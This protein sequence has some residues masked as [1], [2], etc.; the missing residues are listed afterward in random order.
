MPLE[1][2]TEPTGYNFGIYQERST[3]NITLPADIITYPGTVFRVISGQLPRG[4]R[5]VGNKIAG[6]PFEVSRTTTYNFVIRATR[7]KSFSDRTF[8]ITIEGEDEP[9]WLTLPGRLPIGA[10]NAYY[11]IDSSFIDFQLDAVDSDTAAGQQLSYF[12]ASGDGELPPGLILLPTGR[13]TG[14]IQPLLSL[15][16]DKKDAG[17][18]DSTLLDE[19]AYDFGIRSTNGYDSYVYDLVTYDFSVGTLRPRKLN[20]NY[21]FEVTITD[22]DSTSKRRFRIFVVG[23]D[24]FRADNVIMQAGTG[25]YTADITYLRYPV[26][27]TAPYLGTRRGANYQ[28]FKI[29]IYEG[30]GELGPVIY[31]LASVNALIE[32]ICQ[33]EQANDNRAGSN[34]IR[35]IKASAKPKVGNKVN[36]N[37]EFIGATTKTYTITEVDTLGADFYR[38]VLNQPLDVSIP[39]GTAIFLGTDSEI[40]PGM[41][42][43]IA[44]GEIFGVIPFRNAVSERYTFTVKAIR[45]GQGTETNIS[46][47][48]FTVDIIGEIEGA[49]KWI[50]GDDL[51]IINVGYPSTA[52]VKAETTLSNPIVLYKLE[53]G[54]LPPGLSL[55]LDGEIVGKVNQIRNQNRYR[56][57]WNPVISYK[58]KDLVK[59]DTTSEIISV[60]RRQNIASVVVKEDHKFKTNEIIKTI[61]SALDFNYSQGVEISVDKFKLLDVLSIEGNGPYQVK[62]EFSS[63]TL[64]PLAPSYISIRGVA[65]TRD[66]FDLTEVSVK[67]T[68]GQGENARFLISKLQ[69]SALVDPVY[70]S[71]LVNII[72]IDPGQHYLSGDTITISGADLPGGGVDGVN[73]LTFTLATGL[74][75]WYRINGNSNAAYNGRFFAVSSTVNSITLSFDSS[76]LEFGTGLISVATSVNTFE[77]QTQLLALS[78]VNYPNAGKSINMV[79]ATGTMA[80]NPVFYVA[81]VDHISDTEFTDANWKLYNFNSIDSTLTSLDNNTTQFD[82]GETSIDREYNFI[83]RASDQIGFAAISKSFKIAVNIPN[84]TNYSNIYARPFLKQSTRTLFKSFINDPF[85]FD[86]VYIYRASDLNFGIQKELRSLIFAGL[87]TVEVEKYISAMGTNNKSKRFKLGNI[88]KAVA[89]EPGTNTV[90]YEVVYLELID[91]LEKGKQTLPFKISTIPKA[92]NITADNN[93]DFY[94]GNPSTDSPFWNRPI[95]LNAS[96]DRT[97][98]FAGDPRTGVKFVSSISIWRARLRAIQ[99]IARERNYLPLWMRSIQEG[100]VTELDYIT[101]IPLCYCRPGGA[102]EILLNI[103]NSNFDFKLIDYT[104][105]RYIIDSVDGYY[106]D[107]YLVFK[108]DR[109]QIV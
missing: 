102:D 101:A 54:I 59:L 50:S 94:N 104:V 109:T 55:N 106:E 24:F 16:Q 97:D 17:T 7:G 80:G 18:Y 84:D 51:G 108:N 48:V 89:K 19:I 78:Y 91:P 33:N 44:S 9:N 74:N 32:G 81:A 25:T 61:S 8:L 58:Q 107:K 72:L 83:I 26:F 69:N 20:R 34:V 41:Q 73:D 3:L 96:I 36:F 29:D 105:D 37:Q 46:R 76:P 93:N 14:F 5:I 40:P 1:I 65:P 47:R 15:S 42:F 64:T 66:S 100:S 63:Q 38:I 79:P 22:G 28:T 49:I 57:Y 31:E 6:T 2:W 27:T 90:V 70:N 56:G 103:K 60:I 13:I 75:F 62:F 45:F 67:Q 4:T 52:F 11:I 21:E 85:I 53:S 30:L 71:G 82:N 43:D 95:P 92:V 23:D 68:S 98:I 86:A 77:A 99:N 35:F 10:N 87:E 88:K 39:N 12:I